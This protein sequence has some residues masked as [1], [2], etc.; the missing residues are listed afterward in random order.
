M[1]AAAAATTMPA[2][3]AAAVDY[4]PGSWPATKILSAADRHLVGRFSSGITATL[5]RQVVKAGGGRA[6]FV[7]QLAPGSISDPAAAA[8]DSWWPGLAND[9]QTL[10]TNQITG[11]QSGWEV[12]ADY[13]RW[14]MMRRMISKR[15]VL[16]SVT[17][18]L[19]NHL[20]VPVHADGVFTWRRRYGDLIRRKALGKYADLLFAAVTHPAMLI[21]LDAATSTA[22]H[23]NENLG[24][25]LLELHTVGVGNY[26][27][28][29]VKDSARILTGWHVDVWET[30]APS[31]RPE[32]HWTGR[33]RVMDFTHPNTDLDGRAVTRSYLSYLAHHPATAQRL[34]R[35]LAV[36]FVRDTPSQR[37]VDRLASAY[38]ANDTAI[39]PMLTALVDSAE[40]RNSVGAKVRDPAQDVLATYLA[41]NV[42]VAEPTVSGS[43]ANAMLWQTYDL[44]QS[45]FDWPRPDGAPI[46]N[47]SWS[48]ASRALASFNH[49]FG[50]A[51]GWWPT[52]DVTYPDN[53]SWLPA[54]P[55]T[56][57]DLVDHLSRRLLHRPS[58]SKLLQACCLA[59]GYWP[60]AAIT[61]DHDLVKWRMERL[62]ATILDHPAHITR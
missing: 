37:L 50:M 11:V 6:W 7:K 9:P 12:M 26:T 18:C 40:F 25:E 3:P 34:A 61:P 42:R 23:P 35:K 1:T 27:E 45:P 28:A 20:A 57:R 41:L 15:Q 5:R 47:L 17:E 53:A 54:S 49:H 38:L 36:R 55:I 16:E 14:V 43:A 13:Q 56:L 51:A 44:G 58:T 2:G 39:K 24:R 60:G 10:W 8:L 59:T 33:V 4:T 32:D 46:D 62:L 19:E 21:Y 48:S 31:Y 30:W 29:H 52:Q 22:E